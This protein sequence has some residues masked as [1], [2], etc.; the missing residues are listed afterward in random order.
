MPAYGLDTII[1][2]GLALHKH[3]FVK[4]N[5]FGKCKRVPQMSIHRNVLSHNI[6]FP[7]QQPFQVFIETVSEKYIHL[8]APC[9]SQRLNQFVLKSHN[10]IARNIIA[11]GIVPRCHIEFARAHNLRVIANRGLFLEICL[12]QLHHHCNNRKKQKNI[13]KN[14]LFGIH[15]GSIYRC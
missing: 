5:G 12:S 13:Q 6:V 4:R 7:R 11:Y 9:I 1:E 2:C 3:P 14:Q 8:Q 15:I 10:R